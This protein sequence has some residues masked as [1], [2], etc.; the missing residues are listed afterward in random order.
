MRINTVYKMVDMKCDEVG[1]LFVRSCICSYYIQ[2][3]LHYL[4][5]IRK[6]FH[7]IFNRILRGD[8]TAL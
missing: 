7:K 2:E 1:L 3:A 6:T 4:E 8:K 5:L